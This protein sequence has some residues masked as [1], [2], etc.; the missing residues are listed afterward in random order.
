MTV[1][2]LTLYR[3]LVKT[4]ASEAEAEAASSMDTSGLATKA[5]LAELE[6]RLQRFVIIVLGM[7]TAI[8]SAIVG[9]IVRFL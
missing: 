3:L 4:G 2:N 6:A 7:Q 8:F 5:D 1:H 9:I